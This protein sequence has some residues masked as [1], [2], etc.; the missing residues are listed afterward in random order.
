MAGYQKVIDI[1]DKAIGGSTAQVGAHGA[2]W[3]GKTKEQFIG[4]MV[5]GQKLL[6]P[7]DGKD[8]NLVKALRGEAPFGTDKG[9]AGGTFRRM[10]A[11]RPAVKPQQIEV[12]Q[13]WID[14]DCPD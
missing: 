12:I 6:I 10:P 14:D 9:S 1:L 13:K 3:R 7:G 4:T 5:F 2:F 11:G 8:S